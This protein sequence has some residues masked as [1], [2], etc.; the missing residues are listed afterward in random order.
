MWNNPLHPVCTA[1]TSRLSKWALVLGSSLALMAVGPQA[2][3]IQDPVRG[4]SPDFQTI[5]SREGLPQNSA[6]ALSLDAD[7]RLWVATQDGVAAFDGHGWK[8]T[9]R[10]ENSVSNLIRCIA[11]GNDKSLW[12]GYQDG[13]LARLKAGHW[14]WPS[15]P[16]GSAGTRVNALLSSGGK[17]WA[18]TSRQGLGCFDGQTWKILGMEAGL[19]SSAIHCL[20][21]APRGGLWVGTG[22]GLV[23]VEKDHV[24]R[25]EWANAKVDSLLQL[26]DGELLAGTSLGLF[27]LKNERWEPL[28][29]P[30]EIRGK[31]IHALAQTFAADGSSLLWVGTGGG[32]L[33]CRDQVGWRIFTPQ[34]G[35]PSGAIWS[36]LPME[37]PSGTEAL[38][39]GTDGGLAR[40]QFGQW[41]SFGRE[42]GLADPSIYA[43]ALTRGRGLEGSLWLGTRSSGVARI[44]HGRT[45]F[46][47]PKEGLR[48]TTIFS[49][50]E[51]VQENGQS[52]L[53]AGTQSQ[54]LAQFD[55]G[56]W[57]LSQVPS[58][59]R[60]A[61]IRQM[62][63]T[64]DSKGRRVLWLVA[65]GAGLWRRTGDHWDSIATADG[66][67][68]NSLYSALETTGGEGD[69]TLW[70]GTESSGL[71]RQRNG[72]L[73]TFT[74]KDGFPNTTVMSLCETHWNGHHLLWAGTEGGGLV[75]LDPDADK[76]SWNV[77]SEETDPHLP[78]NTVYQ[79]QEDAQHRLYAFT[80]RGVARISGVPGRFRVETFNTDS[81]LPSNEFNGGA[82]MKDHLGRIW[83]GSIGGA[84]VFD[85][86]QELATNSPA[87]LLL[88]Q[89]QV[90]GIMREFSKGTRLGYRDRHLDFG[91]SLLSFFRSSETRYRSQLLGL[92]ESPSDWSP[93]S[94]REFPGLGAGSYVFRLWAK[95]FQGRLSGPV[96]LAFEI[97]SA[98]WRT[99]WA[100]AL[101][102]LLLTGGV[103]FAIRTRLRMLER[104]NEELE[105]KIRQ[106]TQ[107]IEAAKDHIESQNHQIARL[108][109]SSSLAQRDIISWSKAIAEEL[110][111]T[112]GATSIGIYTV[113]GNE[114]RALGESDTR[115]PT[116]QELQAQPYLNPRLDR[117]KHPV[118]VSE[119]RR[120][121]LSIPVQGPSGE[122]LGG[123]VL[124]G[125]FHWGDSERQLVSVFAAQLGAILELQKTRRNLSAA[126]QQ[127]AQTRDNLRERGVALLQICPKCQRCYDE[128][129]THCTWDSGELESP[130]VLP[131]VVQERYQLVRLLG[132]G[133]MGLV[134]EAKDLR[135]DREMA[136][137]LIKPELY[138]M[139]EIRAR[140]TQEAKAL[141]SIEHPG[142]ISIY[143][144]GEL[145]DGSAFMVMELLKGLDLGTMLS[146]YGPG[147]PAQVARLLRQGGAGL[148]AAHRAGVIHRDIKPA[149]IFLIPVGDSFQVKIL[150]FGLAKPMSAEGGVTQTG[151]VV[152][153]PQ[154]MSPEQVRGHTLDARSDVYAFAANG[155]EALTGRRLIS[156]NAVADVFSLIARGEHQA[157]AELVPGLPTSVDAAFAAAL[158]VDPIGR[159]WDI[160]TWVLAFIE[161]LETMETTGTR[162][163]GW[164]DVPATGSQLIQSTT[165][166]T[167]LATELGSV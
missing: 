53:Y 71:V 52:I 38:W 120:R 149:N 83:G 113:Q 133:G 112:I 97:R 4:A 166:P 84:V 69:R 123:M 50:L 26:K 89:V 80:N 157:L 27:R 99:V 122:I 40:L 42:N 31:S 107:E 91:Y 14:D 106:R 116:M 150:D 105:A 24:I 49:L 141:A 77:I 55:Q 131:F 8:I 15:G 115:I 108:M 161:D 41:Q 66:L 142:V 1:L 33:A 36:L 76:P 9:S 29:L 117:R 100:Y 20:A 82:S 94:R 46:Y 45:R 57:S 11:L 75:W 25:T 126:R 2:A 109:E 88:E 118:P 32:G 58:A 70:I 74:L 102:V 167:D 125:P 156:P 119:D 85:P 68:T 56:R 48:D 138:G 5:T 6:M 19:P 137:K 44:E 17:I 153:T 63:E 146:R 98:P 134:F 39:I 121:E 143:D 96:D 86:T 87:R 124:S 160:E 35:L 21:K 60:H 54:G 73:Q 65:S 165:P 61:T 158:S 62:L 103:W 155:Y 154:Y 148:A 145:E 151:M 136:L 127:Q 92:E 34:N 110:A 129:T 16:M 95:D 93:E 59:I 30:Q 22:K 13:G 7:G 101:Y 10:P 47:T 114:L 139:P 64:K 104:K 23:L 162:I 147:T 130:R 51:W 164:P 132:E 28:D 163:P 12:F 67:P 144:T 111:Q 140:F 18:A 152:G 128:S 3:V 37:G 90:N 159:P 81:G 78:N 79:L 135:L 72:K 43:L